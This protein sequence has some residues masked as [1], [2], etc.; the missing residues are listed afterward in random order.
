ME[1]RVIQKTIQ[2]FFRKSFLIY[3][4]IGVFITIIQI[5]CLYLFRDYFKIDD[6]V[7][8][9]LAYI[10]ALVLH[11]FLNKHLTFLIKEKKVFNMMSLRYII[12]VILS[13]CIYVLNMFIFNQLLG[14]KFAISLIL[15]LGVNYIVNY[16]LY[17][18]IVFKHEHS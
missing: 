14:I 16:F 6:F 7:S 12:V 13:Y 11:Y 10:I 9:T 15:T 8:L 18:N 1:L 2:Y 17:E 3:G 5:I 4:L